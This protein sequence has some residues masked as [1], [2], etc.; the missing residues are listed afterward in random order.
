MAS[1]SLEI[2]AVALGEENRAVSDRGAEPESESDRKR[3]RRPRKRRAKPEAI[4]ARLKA[5]GE[6]GA[7]GEGDLGDADGALADDPTRSLI[8]TQVEMGVAIRMACL[9]LLIGET[10]F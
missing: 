6:E 4:A 8:V 10:T 3:R 2:Q 5:P 7:A 1:R 9:E